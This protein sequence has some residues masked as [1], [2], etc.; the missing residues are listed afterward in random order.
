MAKG[1]QSEMADGLRHK[2]KIQLKTSFA[3]ELLKDKVE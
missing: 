3:G 2:K 1:Q